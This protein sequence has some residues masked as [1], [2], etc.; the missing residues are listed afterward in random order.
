MDEGQTLPQIG[1]KMRKAPW[2]PHHERRTLRLCSSCGRV[3]FARISWGVSWGRM[4]S[5]P[6]AAEHLAEV[7]PAFRQLRRVPSAA[8]RR[9]RLKEKCT[10]GIAAP[11]A[12]TL[13]GGSEVVRTAMALL[14][15]EED[16][17]DAPIRRT[18]DIVPGAGLSA[19]FL[20][21]A[22]S[23]YNAT[24]QCRALHRSKV[25]ND[26]DGPAEER[27]DPPRAPRAPHPYSAPPSQ[28]PPPHAPQGSK[29]QPA[30]HW[31]PVEANVLIEPPATW[32]WWRDTSGHGSPTRAHLAS[33][34]PL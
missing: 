3:Y 24:G 18:T 30:R 16:Y 33:V 31:T 10:G 1:S 6:V 14:P 9:A 15:T 27:T 29:R 11:A 23:G 19:L 20:A 2:R 7:L 12:D 17:A 25:V 5:L 21:S 34:N 22:V 26:A 32:S 4:P 8:G 28:P 13:I